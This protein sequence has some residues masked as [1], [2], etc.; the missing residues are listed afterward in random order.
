[1]IGTLHHAELTGPPG[2]RVKEAPRADVDALTPPSTGDAAQAGGRA[3][4]IAGVGGGLRFEA[5]DQ[6]LEVIDEARVVEVRLVV[7]ERDDL[8]V[9]FRMTGDCLT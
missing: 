7:G 2:A 1:M 3:G 5:V 8:S 4:S 6:I 9:A